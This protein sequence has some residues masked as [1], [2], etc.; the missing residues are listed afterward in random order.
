[1]AK[2]LLMCPF[3]DCRKHVEG[4]VEEVGL[5]MHLVHQHKN[6]SLEEKRDI[7]KVAL[8][9]AT[10]IDKSY[11]K[12]TRKPKVQCLHCDRK[13]MFKKGS[14][15]HLRSHGVTEPVEGTDFEYVA[16]NKREYKKKKPVEKGHPQI[17]TPSSTFITIPV[18]LR[19][20]I[21][22]GNATLVEWQSEVQG[23]K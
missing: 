19:I 22:I 21:S 18:M 16:N 15:T 13:P 3:K 17:L 7:V 20:P 23:K 11:D 6:L 5:M 14:H 9:T 12:S 4:C 10:P 1:M 2:L 8:K